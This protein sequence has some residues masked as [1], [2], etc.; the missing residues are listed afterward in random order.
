MSSTVLIISAYPL[1]TSGTLIGRIRTATW[2]NRKY[3]KVWYFKWFLNKFYSMLFDLKQRFCKLEHSITWTFKTR[4]FCKLP[5]EELSSWR[6]PWQEITI[7]NRNNIL[8]FISHLQMFILK[9]SINCLIRQQL[10]MDK[11]RKAD[12]MLVRIIRIHHE[13]FVVD[14]IIVFSFFFSC[15]IFFVF[16][17]FYNI[18]NV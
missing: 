16:Y 2:W 3:N 5:I 14:A 8:T 17:I 9:L 4:S 7:V 6:W 13:P 12:T 1:S 10:S 15:F 18:I 11:I